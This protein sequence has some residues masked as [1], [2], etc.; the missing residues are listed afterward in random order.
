M[1][2]IR[3][4]DPYRRFLGTFVRRWF[5]MGAICIGL[6]VVAWVA[7]PE[8]PKADPTLKAARLACRGAAPTLVGAEFRLS[9]HGAI[10]PATTYHCGYANAATGEQRWFMV[11]ARRNVPPVECEGPFACPH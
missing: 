1:F 9:S 6:G 3:Y 10:E 2:G 7:A 8:A 11:S 4:L 5:I